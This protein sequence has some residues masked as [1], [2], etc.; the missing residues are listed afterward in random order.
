MI[1]LPEAAISPAKLIEVVC[2]VSV[3]VVLLTVTSPP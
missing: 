1:F 3:T 2:A